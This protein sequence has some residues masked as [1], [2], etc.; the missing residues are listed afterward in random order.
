M[1][2]GLQCWLLVDTSRMFGNSFQGLFFWRVNVTLIMDCGLESALKFLG[3]GPCSPSN[4][5]GNASL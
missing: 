1:C 4:L 5:V 3:V 2:Q